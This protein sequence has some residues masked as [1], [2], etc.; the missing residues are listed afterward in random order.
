MLLAAIS[1]LPSATFGTSLGGVARPENTIFDDI[2]KNSQNVWSFLY[3]SGYLNATDCRKS[4]FDETS[5]TYKLS[6]PNLEVSVVFKKFVAQWH[7]KINFNA[8]EELLTAL[9]E[10]NYA[11][12]EY[13]LND[14]MCKLRLLDLGI[15]VNMLVFHYFVRG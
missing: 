7:E 8:T 3:F 14:L 13:H 9:L 2:G 10:E 5:N 15:L 11:D 1:F 6:I 12:F 4:A